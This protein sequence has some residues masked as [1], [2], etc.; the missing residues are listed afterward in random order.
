MDYLKLRRFVRD[1]CDVKVFSSGKE[2]K[3][4]NGDFD[5]VDLVEKAKKFEYNGKFYTKAEMEQI[6]ADS[7]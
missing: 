4:K 2:Q 7:Q 3:L 1:H 6:I 5:V